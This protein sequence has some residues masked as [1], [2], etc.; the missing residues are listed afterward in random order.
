MEP[1]AEM[2][3][4]V[5]MAEMVRQVDAAVMLGMALEAATVGISTCKSMA[6]P[7][8][9]TYIECIQFR[10]IGGQ[11]GNGGSAGARG[12]TGSGGRAGYAGLQV[13]VAQRDRAINMVRVA[14]QGPQESLVARVVKWDYD[15]AMPVMDTTAQLDTLAA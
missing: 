10:S 11:G 5:G 6:T 2:V 8:Q 13:L 15:T 1:V 12:Y 9:T 14:H 3:A 4:T 7:R